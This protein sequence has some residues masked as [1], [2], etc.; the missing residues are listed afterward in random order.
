MSTY[1]PSCGMNQPTD[2]RVAGNRRQWVCVTCGLMLKEEAGPEQVLG[3]VPVQRIS[4]A[5]L[6]SARAASERAAAEKAAAEKAA[7]AAAQARAAA[8]R[9]R[10]NPEP[11]AIELDEM[12]AGEFVVEMSGFEKVVAPLPTS[13]HDPDEGAELELAMGGLAVDPAA[14]AGPQMPPPAPTSQAF[15][16]PAA[17]LS[18]EAVAPSMVLGSLFERVVVAEDTALL[19]EIVKDA[20]VQNGVSQHVRGCANGAEFLQAIAESIAAGLVVD[21]AILDVDMPVLNGYHAAL[22]LRAVERGLR[23]QPTPIVFFTGY[24]CD[25]TF[26]KV[27]EHCQPA[28]YLNK[29]ADASPPRIAGRLV[30]VLA[31]LKR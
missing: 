30:Q 15:P 19:R 10:G 31:S 1:C 28:R 11:Q 23:V 29:G 2:E 25:E 12:P 9:H 14:A 4:A 7:R 17:Q 16:A 22:A 20:L 3:R 8:P 5:E 6:A 26:K 21:L 13:G 18:A 24:P 27:L